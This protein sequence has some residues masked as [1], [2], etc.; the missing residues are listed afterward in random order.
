MRTQNRIRLRYA[1][2]HY[3]FLAF[4]PSPCG[5]GPDPKGQPMLAPTP[6]IAACL[7]E[8]TVTVDC[9][10]ARPPLGDA[11]CPALTPAQLRRVVL[12]IED[13]LDGPLTLPLL[14]AQT[15]LSPSHFA[16]RFKASTGMAPHGYVL[17]RRINAAKKMLLESEMPL[18]EIAVATGFSSQGH[19]TGMFRRHVGITPGG[20][21][22]ERDECYACLMAGEAA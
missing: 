5:G 19:F 1:S 15:G 22:A 6:I 4:R 11:T 21:R 13:N 10:L 3:P 8:E 18:A 7:A 17:A 14:A 9:I 16:R 2:H 20:Y 12:F